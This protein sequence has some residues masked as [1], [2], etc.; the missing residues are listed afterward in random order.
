M[1]RNE[2]VLKLVYIALF[3][4]LTAA[5]SQVAVPTPW[6]P[7]TLQTFAAAL[8]GYMLG[9]KEGLAALAV[10]LLLGAA[11]VPVFANFKAGVQALVGPTGGF[12]FGFLPMAA[13]CGLRMSQKRAIIGILL[14]FLGLLL[15]HA[16]GTLQYALV[17]H[18]GVGR[19]FLLVSLPYLLKDVL[20]VAG[21]Y[22]LAR[23]LRK[24]IPSL[25]A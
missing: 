2:K 12:L 16:A 17:S 18:I 23:V 9:W 11:G 7:L 20:S 15:C 21:A 24:R 22:F 6:V 14:G 4:A 10:Y 19:A 8:C 25:N 3:A 13:L 1:K 5:L